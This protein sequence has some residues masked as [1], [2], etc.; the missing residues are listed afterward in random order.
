[1][2][3]TETTAEQTEQHLFTDRDAYN[4][5]EASTGQ[6]FLNCLIDNLLMRYALS[7]PTGYVVG[8]FL[9]L[10]APDFY[11]DIIYKQGFNYYVVLVMIGYFNFLVYYTFC[12]KVFKGY[13]LG[14]L[15]TGT[16]ALREDGH[17]LTLRDAFLRSLSRCVPFEALSI[18]FGN[19]LWHDT[20]TKTMV[21]KSR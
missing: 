19:G 4:Y 5:T 10:A 21:I 12:E 7:W 6:R 13:T 3:T 14:K 11:S 9:A 1:M 16:R 17:E 8:Y 15:I 2:H 20:W 18:W